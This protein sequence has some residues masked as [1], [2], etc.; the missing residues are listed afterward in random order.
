MKWFKV[1]KK[2]TKIATRDMLL[3][4]IILIPLLLA[5]GIRLLAPG[6][7]DSDLRIAMLNSDRQEVIHY[8]QQVAEV[9]LFDKPEELQERIL[10]RDDL[11]A[12]VSNE[13]HFD[14]ITEGNEDPAYI[15]SAAHLAALY[16][17]GAVK[18]QTTANLFSLQQSV[19]KIRTMLADILIEIIIMLGGMIIAL[20]IIDEKNSN[21]ISAVRVS[22]LSMN[23]FISGKCALGCLVVLISITLSMII[24]DYTHINWMML[25]IIS[26][27]TMI[28]SGVFGL[29]QG[30]ISGD[31]IEAAAGVK[32]L[33]VPIIA[34][35]LVYHLVSE[36]WQWVMYWNP[37]YWAYK[38]NNMILSQTA[39]WSEVLLWSGL[40]LILSLLM[41]RSMKTRISEGL[42]HS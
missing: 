39:N 3:I 42:K 23:Q 15:D 16:E 33:M 36:N 10:K 7:A 11:V 8:M 27:C 13:S 38:A 1:L 29:L 40:V 31:I 41:I 30:V 35:I 6:I 24:L 19:P 26:L 20:G 5:V 37:F 9:E 25:F 32:I 18:E 4:Y 14:I 22:S 12:I 28:L 34:A 17:L 2:D 21:T